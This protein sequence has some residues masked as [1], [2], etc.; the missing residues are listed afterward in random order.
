MGITVGCRGEGPRR[1]DLWQETTKTATL[2]IICAT[3]RHMHEDRN[4]VT[5]VRVGHPPEYKAELPYLLKVCIRILCLRML[6]IISMN[7]HTSIYWWGVRFCFTEI[8]LSLHIIKYPGVARINI[9]VL[10]VILVMKYGCNI[11]QCDDKFAAVS[12]WDWQPYYV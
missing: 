10:F 6:L 7:E 12:L 1:K 2:I 5:P 3:R 9:N 4:L 11:L 8:S